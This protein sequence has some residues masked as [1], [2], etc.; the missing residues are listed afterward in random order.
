V[1]PPEIMPPPLALELLC[2]RRRA[3]TWRLTGAWGLGRRKGTTRQRSNRERGRDTSAN[4][5][6]MHGH[7]CKKSRQIDPSIESTSC[8]YRYQF[9]RLHR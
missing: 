5:V 7:L 2:S 9:A 4:W 6:L 1:P 8:A 3:A